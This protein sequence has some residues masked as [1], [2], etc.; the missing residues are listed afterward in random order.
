MS[1]DDLVSAVQRD[2]QQ[3]SRATVYRTLQWMVDAG[4]A[5]KV[6]AGEGRVRFEHSYRHPRHF[7]LMCQQCSRTFEFFSTD[8]EASI[9][10]VALARGF[11]ARQSVLQVYGTCEG[12][13]SGQPV[14]AERHADGDAVFARDA[15]RVAIATVRSGLEFYTRAARLSDA[16]RDLG[17][18]LRLADDERA[19]LAAL[20]T[21]YK[22]LLEQHPQLES[23]P[24]VLFFKDAANGLFA[25]GAEA[26][27][28]VGDPQAAV[29][30]GTR[31]E[32][33]AH[34]FFR[35]YGER[36]DN[37]EGRRVFLE[38]AGTKRAHLRT[39]LRDLR[40]AKASRPPQ[41]AKR[42]RRRT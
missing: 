13:R 2:D 42:S 29:A 20:E 25:R 9:D 16:S 35:R 40:S 5:R 17:T 18:F 41:A 15:L 24:T 37:A 27:D 14:P 31:C 32:R 7:H 22:L 3:I 10:E 4:F 36:F 30:I 26:L 6:D 11:A 8:I 21:Q 38:L 28:G 23:R 33:G 12:C 39:L 19:H 1:A 34:Q